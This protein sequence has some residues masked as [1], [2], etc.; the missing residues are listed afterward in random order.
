MTSVD[1]PAGRP[2][3]RPIAGRAGR[4]WSP[5]EPLAHAGAAAWR[6]LTDVRFAVVLIS[7]LVLTGMVGLIIRQFRVTA[8][9]DPAR[10]A[11]ELAEME[12]AWSA[13]APM[14]VPVGPAL[15]ELFDRLGLFTVFST[16]WFLVL[17]AVLVLSIVC[18][19]LDRTPRLWS[20]VRDVRVEQPAGFFDP[21][22]DHRA[23]LA[24]DASVADPVGRVERELR[25]Q[26][27]AV[28][29]VVGA[30][31][32][33]T[34][35]YGDRN[36]YNRMATLLTHAGLV[37]FLV[38]GAVTVALGFETMVFVG[39]GQ[40]APV[41]RVGTPGNLMLRVND[42]S[43]PQRE[44]GSF[45]DFA[46]DLTV[47][48]G[49]SEVARK[50]I[51]VND[52]LAIEGFV[53]HQ[54]TF[55]PAVELEIRDARGELAWSGPVILAGELLDHP[56]G[57]LTIPGTDVGLVVLLDRSA[58]GD[59]VVVLQGVG[60]GDPASEAGDTIF[61]ATVPVGA[62]TDPAISAAHE[63]A[64]AG[65]GAWTGV[66][67]KNDPGQP[68]IWVAF[69]LL[70]SGLVLTFYFPRRRVWVRVTGGGAALA[71]I[72]DR[73]VDKDR[74]FERLRDRISTGVRSATRTDSD[75][76]AVVRD[77]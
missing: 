61:L 68:L 70:I 44:D 2:V 57:F 28:R 48:R 37:L 8:A 72:A 31:G 71:F 38:G 45:A 67:V 7:L 10:Y 40:S 36:R 73:Y 4:A 50:T 62:S 9:D 42:F 54:N 15:V 76:Q 52:P 60:R 56:Q 13:I 24:V 35:V 51:R 30:D 34:Y 16:P 69:G 55:G 6:L 47:Y 3:D 27:Y 17:M 26:R 14:G 22:L 53:F 39:E 77:S 64:V 43:A 18:C 75:T 33:A 74:E 65:I 29:S 21:A 12:R 25:R 20:A 49:G 46:T 66:V 63:I 58:A 11:I 41:Q 5:I 59:P 19:T 32:T 1:R 23:G